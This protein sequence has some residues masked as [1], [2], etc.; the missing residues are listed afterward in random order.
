[1]VSWKF[2]ITTNQEPGK[3]HGPTDYHPRRQIAQLPDGIRGRNS[4]IPVEALRDRTDGISAL[5]GIPDTLGHIAEC[6]NLGD[7]VAVERVSG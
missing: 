6:R 3:E 5:S 7:S 2:G 4:T 1:M